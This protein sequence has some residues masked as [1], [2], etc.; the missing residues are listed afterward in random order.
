MYIFCCGISTRTIVAIVGGHFICVFPVAF[1]Y[2]CTYIYV[3]VPWHVVVIWETRQ[4]RD[5]TEYKVWLMTKWKWIRLLGDGAAVFNLSIIQTNFLI[6]IIIIIVSGVS[7]CLIIVKII[8]VVYY[9]YIFVDWRLKSYRLKMM[10]NYWLRNSRSMK[11]FVMCEMLPYR[12]TQSRVVSNC[13]CKELYNTT[14]QP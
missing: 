7:V 3:F 6:I 2:I 5:R 9:Y 11:P 12:V 14:E 8:F 1:I 4:E 10:I 13:T